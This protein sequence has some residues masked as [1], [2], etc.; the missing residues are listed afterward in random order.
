MDDFSLPEGSYS[1]DIY[2]ASDTELDEIAMEDYL[3]PS[4]LIK[5]GAGFA[6]LPNGIVAEDLNI[7]ARGMCH[8]LD[9][10]QTTFVDGTG[11]GIKV[12]RCENED[13]GRSKPYFDDGYARMIHDFLEG[14]LFQG[15]D[16]E[17]KDDGQLYLRDRD[18]SGDNK[19]LDTFHVV[20][21]QSEYAIPRQKWSKA[22]TRQMLFET[23]RLKLRVLHGIKFRNMAF[24]RMDSD[25]P[26]TRL[27]KWD[28]LFHW[29][30][31]LNIDADYTFDLAAQAIQFLREMTVDEHSA[32]N[33]GRYFATP[34]L[35]PYKHLS[36]VWYGGGG[37]GKGIIAKMLKDSFGD[38]ARSVDAAK[39]LG[40]K[41]GNGGF[42][43]DNETVKLLGA[44]WAWDDDADEITIDQMTVLKKLSTGDPLSARRVQENTIE[45]RPKATF[46]ICTNNAVVMSSNNAAVRRQVKV[47]MRDGRKEE[48]FIPLRMFIKEHG[49]AP[50]I[51]ASCAIWERYGN[52]PYKDVVIGSSKD[53][54]QAQQWVVDSIVGQGYAVSGENPYRETPAE[55]RNTV[56]KLGLA[57]KVRKR[58]DGDKWR[59]VR[60]LIVE[61]ERRFQPYRDAAANDELDL[62]DASKV[63]Q[64]PVM[65]VCVERGHLTTP[66]QLGF[67]CDYVPADEHK[68]AKQ[69][70]HKVADKDT[71]TSKIPTSKAY[72]VVPNTGCAVL[73]MDVS[74][75]KGVPDGWAVLNAAVGEYGSEAFPK[76]Y[77]VRTPS[78]GY[79][80]YYQ[81]PKDIQGRLKNLAHPGTPAYPKKSTGGV[82]VDTRT[83]S[84]GYV[85]GATSQ[86]ADGDYKLVDLPDGNI[87][88]LS[89]KLVDWLKTNGYVENVPEPE[90]APNMVRRTVTRPASSGGSGSADRA[91]MSPIAEGSRNDT[92]Y[93]WGFG[94]LKNHPEDKN[95][96]RDDVFERGRA[97][98]LRDGELDVLWKSI[99]SS[100]SSI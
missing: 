2:R 90:T 87:P 78:G 18:Y 37:N 45:V 92:L 54:T 29:P 9:A 88:E 32:Q 58:Q 40:G 30:F 17:G 19:R 70:Q 13:T 35:E 57:S 26:V 47:R 44:L 20:D 50:F 65:E 73:D 95:R 49:A 69:W 62:I 96:I 53:L 59:S 99:L 84:R 27:D 77:L 14:D 1:S 91:D 28:K 42:A 93:R 22:W 55:H 52:D 71:D 51:M 64:A 25:S 24:I 74:K 6:Q 63:P 8:T 72:G 60:V 21:L 16:I 5:D 80:A 66:D 43:T 56:A 94:R 3:E 89:A 7:V 39:L 34:L 75:H 61:D 83:E 46:A 68:V 48:E 82:P 79:H 23:S 11:H 36:W 12:P 10:R 100:A 41:T 98:G 15:R 4:R 33:L 67:K 31:E 97:S 86:V 81:V 85:I 38:L 76:T